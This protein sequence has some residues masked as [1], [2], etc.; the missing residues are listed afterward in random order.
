MISP[1]DK[2]FKE[3]FS[4]KEVAESF[5]KSYLP[6]ELLEIMD[7]SHL[8]I[9]KD[10]FVDKKLKEYFSVGL[11]YILEIVDYDV[12]IMKQ[13]VDTIIPER[14]EAFMSTANKLREEGREEGKKEELIE[15]IIGLTAQKLNIEDFPPVLKKKLN[16]SQLET[17]KTIRNNILNIES[18]KDLEGY[19]N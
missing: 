6:K 16:N 12:D 13:K 2:F 3:M 11:R 18:L 17:L 1:H 5:I 4:K 8:E 10:S 7:S 19:L 9:S 15:T 14:S